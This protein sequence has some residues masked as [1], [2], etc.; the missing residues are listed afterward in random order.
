MFMYM[1]IYKSGV[2]S[3][4]YLYICIYVYIYIH[5]YMYIYMYIYKSGVQSAELHGSRYGQRCVATSRRT[6]TGILVCCSVLQ[7]VAVCC[8][9]YEH[10]HR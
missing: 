8:H 6:A 2:Q 7:C 10:N 4:E 9:T 1:Y 3:A 5:T